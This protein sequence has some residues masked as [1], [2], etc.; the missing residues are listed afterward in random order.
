[1]KAIL[2]LSLILQLLTLLL[3]G[4]LLVA[5]PLGQR[6]VEADELRSLLQGTVHHQQ[7]LT[8]FLD[9]L[10]GDLVRMRDAGPPGGASQAAVEEEAPAAPPPEPAQPMPFA[11]TRQVLLDLKQ[12]FQQQ[13]QRRE[14][15]ETFTGPLDSHQQELRTELLRRGTEALHWVSEELTRQPWDTERDPE[16]MEYLL[17]EVLAPLSP[18]DSAASFKLARQALIT[19]TNEPVVRQAAAECLRSI[20]SQNWHQDVID[21]VRL[22]QS[23]KQLTTVK[24]KLL[25]MFLAHPRAEV[26]ETCQELVTSTRAPL[27]LRIAGVQVLAAQDSDVADTTLANAVREDPALEIKLA[28]LD[29]LYQRQGAASRGFLEALL[30]E[31]SARM[32]G[33]V[34]DKVRM[35][36]E[37]LAEPD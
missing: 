23:G 31:D 26:V 4:W 27:P 3:V 13:R 24:V 11:E 10:R 33:L 25:R 34:K 20:D 15:D 21:V 28:A 36:I 7:Q 19:A 29:G 5:G 1:M 16:F 14:L 2:T 18:A 22:A 9:Q 35:L 32:P 37:R 17:A 30:A 12:A 8:G 6:P